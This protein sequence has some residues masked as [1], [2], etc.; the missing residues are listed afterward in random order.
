MVIRNFLVTLELFFNAKCSL[1]L[2][3]KL[4]IGHGKWFPNT[5]LFLI[6]KFDCIWFFDTGWCNE[7]NK[8]LL[9]SLFPIFFFRRR[10]WT[11]C[12][13]FGFCFCQFFWKKIP[14]DVVPLSQWDLMHF[15]RLCSSFCTRYV[16]KKMH[17]LFCF[18][19]HSV[20]SIRNAG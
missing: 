19:T 16:P 13:Y 1:F 14:S 3:S 15:R 5:N 2:W 7:S 4:Q 10:N 18:Y 9:K 8:N 20:W 17:V 11:C 6:T 12:L